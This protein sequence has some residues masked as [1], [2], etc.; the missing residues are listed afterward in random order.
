MTDL[1][2][3]FQSC[4]WFLGTSIVKPRFV[5][6]LNLFSQSTLLKK[7][8]GLLLEDAT[9]NV[10]VQLY[11][12]S[13]FI[14]TGHTSALM[15]L[16]RFCFRAALHLE[17]SGEEQSK[18]SPAWKT[19]ERQTSVE[20]AEAYLQLSSD[21]RVI[22]FQTQFQG[23]KVLHAFKTSSSENFSCYAILVYSI[24]HFLY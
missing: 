18:F 17:A 11:F 6:E 21:I 2:D 14:S 1:T 8:H 15:H 24:T 19:P 20:G 16:P 7:R 12:L 3:I 10:S 4:T 13:R 9:F 22:Q 23:L 5:L